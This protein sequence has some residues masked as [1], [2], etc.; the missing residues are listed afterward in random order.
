MYSSNCHDV[1]A[2]D[3]L[4]EH[5]GGEQ[6][7]ITRAQQCLYRRDCAFHLDSVDA[8]VPGYLLAGAG[9]EVLTQIAVDLLTRFIRAGPP[10]RRLLLRKGHPDGE[11]D[12]HEQCYEAGQRQERSR[13]Q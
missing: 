11:E 5:T 8:P 1:I 3:R 4:A 9:A 7:F 10:Y 13:D 12:N 6:A 2:D